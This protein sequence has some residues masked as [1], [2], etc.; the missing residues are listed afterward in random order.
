MR[1]VERD[2]DELR[3]LDQPGEVFASELAEPRHKHDSGFHQRRRADTADFRPDARSPK[4]L[5]I[6]A[7]VEGYEKV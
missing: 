3:T 7:M 2:E 5:M 1:S 6:N 4:S